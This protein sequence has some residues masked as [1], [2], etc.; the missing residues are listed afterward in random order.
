M[1]GM[2][3]IEVARKIRETEERLPI[4]ITTTEPDFAV[5]GFAVH[6]MD[7]LVKPIEKRKVAWCLRELR[8]YTAVPAYVEVREVSSRGSFQPRLIALD[9]IHYVRSDKHNVVI[10]TFSGDVRV[11]AAFQGGGRGP[12]DGTGAPRRRSA[13][14]SG[15][16]KL[17]GGSAGDN[18]GRA[19]R[20]AQGGQAAVRRGRHRSLPPVWWR[21]WGP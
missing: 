1:G 12:G 10:H 16:G 21:E 8:E 5:D 6:V 4:I 15:H 17:C 18:G 2:S 20:R 9:D 14:H 11:R 7:F 3:G 13:G 19:G